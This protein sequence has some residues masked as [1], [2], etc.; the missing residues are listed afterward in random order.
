MPES[1]V[2][3]DRRNSRLARI[4]V[5]AAG[6]LAQLP[7]HVIRNVL[8]V[9]VKGVARAEPAAV[10]SWR[11]AVNSVSRRCAGEGCL[12]RSIAVMLLGRMFGAAPSWKTGFRPNPFIAHAWVEVDGVPIG[13]PAAVS[14][15]RTVLQV[16]PKH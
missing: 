12:Q 11:D 10:L 7:P 3:L 15:F 4:A 8:T 13:E 2:E 16:I 1:R 9:V 5:L 14:Q 6:L